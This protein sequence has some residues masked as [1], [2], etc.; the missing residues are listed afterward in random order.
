[1]ARDEGSWVRFGIGLLL[2][3]FVLLHSGLFMAAVL[4][5][6]RNAAN[7]LG[8]F[9]VLTGFYALLAWAFAQSLD[10]PALLWIFSAVVIGRVLTT[11]SGPEMSMDSQKARSALGVVLYIAVVAGTIF[12]PIPKWGITADV[13]AD[14]YPKR[15]S[16]IWE[17][18]PHRAIAGAAVYFLLLGLAEMFLLPRAPKNITVQ[19]LKTH[20]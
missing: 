11:V 9:L 14:V 13:V 19:G 4:H 17:Q 12:L 8:Y 3:E 16:G 18:Q 10:S 1:M 15:G 2:L 7:K 6:E 20:E 5:S